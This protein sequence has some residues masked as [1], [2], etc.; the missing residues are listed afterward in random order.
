MKSFLLSLAI[1]M[2]LSG[3]V[4]T[5]MMSFGEAAAKVPNTTGNRDFLIVYNQN[6]QYELHNYRFS[7]D[8]LEGQIFVPKVDRSK[9]IMVYTSAEFVLTGNLTESLTKIPINSIAKIQEVKP[10]LFRSVAFAAGVAVIT[11]GL[12][13]AGNLLMGGIF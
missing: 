4:T 5:K 7:K 8:T 3:C 12:W 10:D 6:N 13:S 11:F 9:G 1:L 2:L